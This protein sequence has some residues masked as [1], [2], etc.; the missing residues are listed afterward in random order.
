MK[1]A[2]AEK[3]APSI[4]LHSSPTQAVLVPLTTMWSRFF[5][6]LMATPYTGPRANAPSRA[7]RSE[8][9][10]L[11]KDGMSIGTG[12]SMNIRMNATAL[13]MAA[14]VRLWVVSFL[15]IFLPGRLPHSNKDWKALFS[16]AGTG[17]TNENAP[18]HSLHYNRARTN[19]SNC[20]PFLA[21][22]LYRW[23]RSLTGS[24]LFG[25]GRG[26]YRQ[27]GI[28]PRPETNFLRR[29]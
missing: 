18:C 20:L 23:P 11:T 26:L 6:K 19:K 25:S 8:K 29:V 28:A 16:L 9:S 14:T 5:M 17:K 4:K 15:I 1:P 22:G 24:A 13:S 10:I 27:W 2:T 12:N 3:T 21:S 7:G